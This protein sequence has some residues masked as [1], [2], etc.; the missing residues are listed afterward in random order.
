MKKNY[1]L[2]ESLNGIGEDLLEEALPE[3]TAIAKIRPIRRVLPIAAALIAAVILLILGFTI[4]NKTNDTA[5][6]LP[7]GAVSSP[8]ES[9]VAAPPA[10][11]FPDE[12]D[13]TEP[14]ADVKYL[15]TDAAAPY[16]AYPTDLANAYA[17]RLTV[18]PTILKR[19]FGDEHYGYTPHINLS[20]L[21]AQKAG[22]ATP[23]DKTD[24]FLS[25]CWAFLTETDGVISPVNLYTALS[26]LA[27]GTDGETRAQIMRLLNAESISEVEKQAD[28]EWIRLFK[29]DPS[30]DSAAVPAASLWV[31]EDA[32]IREEALDKLKDSIH[33]SVF[34]GEMGSSGLNEALRRWLDLYTGEMLPDAVRETELEA[35]T[36]LSLITT[37]YYKTQWQMPFDGSASFTAPFYTPSGECETKFLHA[38]EMQGVY[39]ET[40]TAEIGVLPLING[41]DMVFLLPKNGG[42]PVSLLQD[43]TADFAL[44]ANSRITKMAFLEQINASLGLN[45]SLPEFDVTSEIDLRDGLSFLG[46]SDAFDPAKADFG[47][48]FEN[49]DGIYLKEATHTARVSV[50]KNGVTGAAFTQAN[51]FTTGRVIHCKTLK[52]D[53][54]FLFFILSESTPIFAGIVSNP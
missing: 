37:L 11:S 13:T 10:V 35:G 36:L 15:E 42:A 26:A 44:R 48:L 52:L 18:Y 6:A 23:A 24:L 41:D 1:P 20:L 27:V 7:S 45:I 53:H 30:S 54:P 34:Q 29:I 16:N 28:L 32:E 4:R 3:Q 19:D 8:A 49:E 5:I 21:E 12:T 17:R 40:D 50:D 47:T 43:G 14:A 33:A 39:Y 9:Q 51:V 31:S 2:S 22:D 38:E 46:V 25:L